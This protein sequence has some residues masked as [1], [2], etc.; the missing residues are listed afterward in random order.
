MTN[1][2]IWN[3]KWREVSVTGSSDDLPSLGLKQA[4]VEGV[5]VP[6]GWHGIVEPLHPGE[7]GQS[8]VRAFMKYFDYERLRDNFAEQ[9]QQAVDQRAVDRVLDGERRKLLAEIEFARNAVSGGPG[10]LD[11]VVSAEGSS[12]YVVYRYLDPNTRMDRLLEGGPHLQRALGMVHAVF[13]LVERLHGGDVVHGKLDER[14]VY[15]PDVCTDSLGEPV[16]LPFAPS[17]HN[18]ISELLNLVDSEVASAPLRHPLT[19]VLP[20]LHLAQCCG[21]PVDHVSGNLLALAS[22]HVERNFPGLYREFARARRGGE[23]VLA[24]HG[25][26]RGMLFEKSR[27]SP[28]PNPGR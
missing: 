9:Y 18:Q 7:A 12:L 15:F 13:G 23:F 27:G 10:L 19:R 3:G 4:R 22:A 28:V 21:H 5:F 1:E 17:A 11:A 14:E 2:K 25:N 6:I 8:P 24:N 16:L 20:A 26:A